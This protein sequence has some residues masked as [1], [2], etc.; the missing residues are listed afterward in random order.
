MSFLRIKHVKKKGKPIRISCSKRTSVR[1]KKYIQSWSIFAGS[2]W[3]HYRRPGRAASAATVRLISGRYA[4]RNRQ[5]V[6]CLQRIGAPFNAKQ[7]RDYE[8]GQRVRDAAKETKDSKLSRS[9]RQE[10]ADAKEAAE[11]KAAETMETVREF[12]EARDKEKSRL[13]LRTALSS[14]WLGGAN[15]CTTVTLFVAIRL[16]T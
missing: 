5:T 2:A 4:T 6:S 15:L 13:A 10:R 9:E 12:N 16:Q 3:R 11:K 7:R 14:L 8:H 1:A